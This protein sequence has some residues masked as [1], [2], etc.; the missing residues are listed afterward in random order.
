M[1]TPQSQ[2]QPVSS[3]QTRLKT[4]TMP[5]Q[6]KK[7]GEMLLQ[8]GLINEASL[9]EALV[10]SQK[11]GQFLGGVLIRQGRISKDQL[12][13]VLS[14]QFNVPYLSL[15]KLEVDRTLLALLPQEFMQNNR[16]LPVAKEGGKLIVAMVEPTN[17]RIQ[18]EIT[19]MTGIRPQ[20]MVTTSIEFQE[21]F[22]RIF[23]SKDYTNLFEEINTERLPESRDDQI[24]MQQQQEI[25]DTSNP[26]VKL[27]NSIFEEGI[28]KGISDVHIEPRR[29]RYVIR[30][31]QDG[32][33]KRFIDVPS[34]MESSFITRVKVMA[35]LDIAEH[36][37]PQDGRITFNY[38][39]I[40]YNIRVSC[41]PVGESGKEKVVCR[42]LRPSKQIAS[43]DELGF[44]AID[45][46]KLEAMYKSPY[47]I[48]LICGPT[49][50]GK[51][52]TLYTILNQV[53][54]DARN[55]ST[56]EDPIELKLEGINQ[57]Q[58]NNKA[59]FTFASALRALLRQDPDV[60]MV[61]EIRDYE[62]LESS[63]HASLTGHLVFS[64][65]HA[66]TTAATVTRLI[67]MGADP[68]LICSSLLG[69]VAQ[70]LVRGVCKAC[71]KPYE[72]SAEEKAL[73]FPKRQD[74]QEKSLTLY[75]GE[76]C[77]LCGESGYA[78]RTGL[79][80][81]MVIDRKLRHL[82]SERRLD[83]EI[84]DAAV[85]AGMKTMHMYGLEAL[86]KGKTTVEEL[87]R[88]LG[89]TLGRS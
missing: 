33:L 73:I 80:E 32:I 12:G 31:R 61:G 84:E 58:V 89:T 60:L 10:E 76:G 51:T 82:I 14:K 23:Q 17:R 67:E 88:V 81:I 44:S 21:A 87:I 20:A 2:I 24:R 39:N 3:S 83:L 70:R 11:T 71:R 6:Q 8:E 77:N 47:G 68:N 45:I 63:I 85:A 72:A 48:L 16:V 35:R 53:N 4:E 7:L 26:L 41:M 75:K 38:K 27:V 54:D 1:V 57:S 49:G 15:N 66:N 13:N 79:Y 78:G 19:F 69:V 9:Q 29:D 22:S 40:E 56:I 25:L 52:T 30:F 34:H 28:E 55:I 18:D 65:I 36:R 43:F 59:D 74:L 62:T 64:T 5:G 50:S 86:I 42:I 37:R 46:K